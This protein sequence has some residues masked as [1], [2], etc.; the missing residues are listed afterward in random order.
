ML[1]DVSI[2]SVSENEF[3]V[4]FPKN[5]R[6]RFIIGSTK[7]TRL[8]RE[9]DRNLTPVDKHPN[10]SCSLLFEMLLVFPQYNKYL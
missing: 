4:F 1:I 8:L 2:H 5:L 10:M 3:V 7:K 6:L 9:C